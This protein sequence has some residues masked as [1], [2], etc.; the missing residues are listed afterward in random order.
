[1]VAL[2]S[3]A[4]TSTAHTPPQ[5]A[6]RVVPASSNALPEGALGKVRSHLLD[7]PIEFTLPAK[8]SWQLTEGPSWLVLE[9]RPS[10]SQLA[11]RTW[12]ADRLLRRAEC[13]AQAR[14]GRKAIPIVHEEA[15]VDRHALLAP[16][17]FD[18]ELVV[19]VEPSALGLEGYAL[20]IGASV[21]RC[22]AAVFTTRVSGERAELEVAARL[23]LVV[24][25]ILSHVRVLAVDERAPRR[26]LVVTPKAA[27]E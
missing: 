18:N 5:S 13:E 23:G 27:T 19:G 16:A 14:L 12:R 1:M 26:H 6:P 20:V 4:C 10:S 7:F 22:Y 21:G 9:H 11:L 2:A 8:A 24:D 17:D 3:F 25:R 15:V